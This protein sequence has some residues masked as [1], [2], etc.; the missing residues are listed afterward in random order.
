MTRFSKILIGSMVFGELPLTALAGANRQSDGRQ[1]VR[2]VSQAMAAHRRQIV[3]SETA[4]AAAF[5]VS[6]RQ[7]LWPRAG[8]FDASIRGAAPNA[9]I[10]DCC[11]LPST[12]CW[13]DKRII[14]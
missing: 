6:Q 3:R 10:D 1:T 7:T 8:A 11:D 9:V 13:N 4:N 5:R 2:S 12:G 14:N